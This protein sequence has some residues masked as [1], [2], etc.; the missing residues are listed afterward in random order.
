[1]GLG[2]AGARSGREHESLAEGGERIKF[3]CVRVDGL[4]SGSRD[5][6]DLRS[7]LARGLEALQIN[8]LAPVGPDQK[9]LGN[10]CLLSSV[11]PG[12]MVAFLRTAR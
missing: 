1:M 7:D 4:A 12:A 2:G 5:F 8:N 11:V 6:L 3:S 10:V 9:L